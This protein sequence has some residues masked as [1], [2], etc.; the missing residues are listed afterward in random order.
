M[1]MQAKDKKTKP[2]KDESLVN[3][4]KESLR[5]SIQN[6]NQ[7]SVKQERFY[8]LRMRMR[9]GKKTFPFDGASDLRMPTG[10]TKIRKAKAAIANVIFGTR[11]IVQ[12]I[13]SAMMDHTQASRIEK[14]VDHLIMD[15]IDYYP[16]GLITIDQT[17]EKGMYFNKPYWRIETT[18]RK[19][20]LKAEDFDIDQLLFITD[21]DQP[22]EIKIESLA[23]ELEADMS[24]RVVTKNQKALEEALE[25][26]KDGETDI[27]VT[28][29]DEIYDA[30]DVC[31]VSPEYLFVPSNSPFELQ[32][33]ESLCH[34]F[35]LSR[36]AVKINAMEKGWDISGLDDLD[37]YNSYKP[38]TLSD[39]LKDRREGIERLQKTGDVRIYEFYT[40]YDLDG[41]GFEEKCLITYAPDFSK[42]LRKIPLS[43]KRAQWPIVKFVWEVLDDRFY[44][45]R[46]II[47]IIED[48]I[49]E[50][51][52]Q[53]MQKIDKQ[54]ICNNPMFVYRVGM[55]N[56]NTVKFQLGQG[57]PVKGSLDLK[58]AID[59]INANNP[60][61]EF[62]N[63]REEQ[64][65]LGRIEELI[66]QVDFTLQSQ[67]NRREPRTLGEVNL[68]ASNAQT[69][70]SMDSTIFSNCFS[71]L[72]NMIWELWC[73]HGKD[74]YEFMYSG[75][76]G[77]E[78]IK[79][80]REDLQSK[81]KLVLRGNDQSSNPQ[82]RL[83]KAQA[84]L[85]AST[86]PI[87]L[88]TGVVGPMQIAESYARYYQTLDIP[89]WER[90]VNMQPQPQPQEQP[91]INPNFDQLTDA[92]KMQVL[93][94]FGVRPDV[95]GRYL[96]KMETMSG[97]SNV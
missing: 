71:R 96:N 78:T 69:V 56:P 30:P 79:I 59:V 88:Q 33:C 5:D 61:I 62:S 82:I 45:S 58:N 55:V 32:D 17:L 46:G 74:S 50:I 18:T 27:E 49:K 36:R 48:I 66:G 16:K 52:I 10:D 24:D 73:E 54:T 87:A 84:I 34:D 20:N 85:Q 4:I 70:F 94:K 43:N 68:Q 80:T 76:E 47:E 39:M 44:A 63:E 97:G 13:P 31:L 23:E 3:W 35:C 28:L 89:N 65:L 9:E 67:I 57:I 14:F 75:A 21:P 42:V 37:N 90:L 81:C 29:F 11:P 83:N 60:N 26:I 12:A 92:E 6:T 38:E 41:D 95:D 15:K 86:N 72:F 25:K 53:H 8:K 1:V 64:N 77:K 91:Q 7:Y 93:S 2:N 19:V 51:D 40:W 22:D